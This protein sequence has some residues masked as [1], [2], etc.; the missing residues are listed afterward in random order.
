MCPNYC[1]ET[2]AK[3]NFR[4]SLKSRGL[5]NIHL[6]ATPRPGSSYG[7][8]SIKELCETLESSS[9]ASVSTINILQQLTSADWGR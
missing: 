2:L 8:K 1:N 9:L 3:L 7:A 6:P 4:I 5:L